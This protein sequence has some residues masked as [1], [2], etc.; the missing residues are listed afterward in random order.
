MTNMPNSVINCHYATLPDQVLTEHSVNGVLCKQC[1]FAVYNLLIRLMGSFS[2]LLIKR[3][4]VLDLSV[5]TC[6][7]L[8]T[9]FRH[10]LG[11]C[12]VSTVLVLAILYPQEL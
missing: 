3:C 5:C 8:L 1:V 10:C 11:E 12:R 9:F 7:K 4:A 6:A 2:N